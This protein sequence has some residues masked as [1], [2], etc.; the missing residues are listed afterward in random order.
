M[1]PG[2]RPQRAEA[3]RR[4]VR[5]TARGE[6]SSRRPRGGVRLRRRALGERSDPGAGRGGQL[7]SRRVLRDRGRARGSYRPPR[8]ASE[9]G[10]LV[11]PLLSGRSRG[12]ARGRAPVAGA[13]RTR[14]RGAA[15]RRALGGC[16]DDGPRPAR[17]DVGVR[18]RP[19]NVAP[20]RG[21]SRRPAQR[22][23]RRRRWRVPARRAR[24]SRPPA[25]ARD[26]STPRPVRRRNLPLLRQRPCVPGPGV[27]RRCGRLGSRRAGHLGRYAGAEGRLER[28]RPGGL[29]RPHRANGVRQRRPAGNLPGRGSARQGNEPPPRH[30]SR[31][32]GCA[33]AE[34]GRYAPGRG[35]R[36][37]AVQSRRR[38]SARRS[39]A[40]RRRR[41]EDAR[42]VDPRG[43]RVV[44]LAASARPE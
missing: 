6:A 28:H 32:D 31:L 24:A 34:S 15:C 26:A 9:W 37:G 21:L 19:R 40:R 35:R 13:R 44:G 20:P 29:V 18:A 8:R 7:G 23:S 1:R 30:A 12:A 10:A 41:D 42:A 39:R 14:A 4:S 11:E 33:R 38:R 36:P 3:G 43:C 27:R 2:R 17:A 25:C 16:A 5:R 22:R